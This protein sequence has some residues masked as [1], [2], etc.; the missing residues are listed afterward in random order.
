L[1]GNLSKIE[2]YNEDRNKNKETFMCYVKFFIGT[3]PWYHNVEKSIIF[4]APL[5]GTNYGAINSAK[6]WRIVH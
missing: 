1:N 3:F 2:R 4:F 6:K 5:I